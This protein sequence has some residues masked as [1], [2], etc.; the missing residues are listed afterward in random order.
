MEHRVSC[1]VCGKKDIVKI[2]DKTFKIF[3]NWYYYGKINVNSTQTDK[4][5]HRV[6]SWKPRFVTKKIV[7]SEYNKKAK[8]KLIEY[9]ECEKCVS[10]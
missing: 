3:G 6:I 5:V 2:D 10:R 1:V 4:Y 9:W 7:N 8:P